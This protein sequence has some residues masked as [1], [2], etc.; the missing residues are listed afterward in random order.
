MKRCYGDAEERRGL[1][2]LVG[3]GC[4]ARVGDEAGWRPRGVL[5]AEAT[6]A[7]DGTNG[8]GADAAEGDVVVAL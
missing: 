6:V 7:V 1:R 2:R 3:D 8:G 5:A 4:A